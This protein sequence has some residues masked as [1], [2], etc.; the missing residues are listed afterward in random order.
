M[1]LWPSAMYASLFTAL[2]VRVHLS[3]S[4]HQAKHLES[5]TQTINDAILSSD[6]SGM[7]LSWNMAAEKM[8]QYSAVEAPGQSLSIIVPDRYKA[9]HEQ[10]IQRIVN[11][12]PQ[13]A[14]MLLTGNTTQTG[15]TNG[16]PCGCI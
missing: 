16:Y 1:N 10:R 9:A 8:F 3:D 4:N 5:I 11:G 13:H 7:I 6:Q 12:G 2:S 14:S 15:V